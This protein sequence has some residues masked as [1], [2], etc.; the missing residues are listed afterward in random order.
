MLHLV[1]ESLVIVG[2]LAGGETRRCT[3]SEMQI[4]DDSKRV[5]SSNHRHPYIK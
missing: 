5:D 4:C 3:T 1:G 2:S